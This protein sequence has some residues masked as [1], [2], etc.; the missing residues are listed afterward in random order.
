MASPGPEQPI[1][2]SG[3]IK[4]TDTAISCT[5]CGRGKEI[6]KRVLEII[7]NMIFK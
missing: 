7:D 1:T 5:G 6:N 2:Q 4:T 3:C